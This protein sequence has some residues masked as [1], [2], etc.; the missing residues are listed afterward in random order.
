MSSLHT[1]DSLAAAAAEIRAGKREPANAFERAAA[2][3]LELEPVPVALDVEAAL[4]SSLF[5]ALLSQAVRNAPAA[6]NSSPALLH[7]YVARVTAQ[8]RD[9]APV[10][11]MSLLPFEP[12]KPPSVE[13]AAAERAELERAVALENP[14]ASLNARAE[15]A[16]RAKQLAPARA[17]EMAKAQVEKE[18]GRHLADARRANP[19][20][21]RE[22]IVPASQVE[23]LINVAA[24]A[25]LPAATAA[26]Q[27]ELAATPVDQTR[28]ALVADKAR[29]GDFG[30]L[31][32]C[33]D[34]VDESGAQR[35]SADDQAKMQLVNRAQKAGLFGQLATLR[36]VKTDAVRTAEVVRP[37]VLSSTWHV[38]HVGVVG[39]QLLLVPKKRSEHPPA[40]LAALADGLGQLERVEL[41]ANHAGAWLFV[42]RAS[43]ESEAAE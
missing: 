3:F 38:P 6:L 11:G 20:A 24:D 7:D 30:S 10:A 39:A 23:K 5:S 36:V 26:L 40:E 37:L 32:R 19:K 34:C 41:E 22:D 27:R 12:A 21:R 14:N 15:Q 18:I 4:R 31:G 43:A 8:V 1:R 42:P 9:K 17:R 25:A 29:R 16:A 28:T 13:E 2:L 33:L 35:W